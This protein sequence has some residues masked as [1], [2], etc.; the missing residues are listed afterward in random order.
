MIVAV[1]FA[2]AYV[3]YNVIIYG[4]PIYGCFASM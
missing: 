2:S 4:Q 1:A 3:G